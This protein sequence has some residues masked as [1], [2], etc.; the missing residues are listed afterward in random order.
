M[1]WTIIDKATRLPIDLT[2][3][4]IAVLV[5]SIDETTTIINRNATIIDATAGTCKLVPQTGE[6]DTAG[7]YAVQLTITFSDGTI[8]YIGDMFLIVKTART[9]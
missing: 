1:K 2:G 7:D 5:Q 3:S 4:T 8:G 9:P 6:M